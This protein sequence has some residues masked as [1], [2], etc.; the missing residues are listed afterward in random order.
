MGDSRKITANFAASDIRNNVVAEA[1]PSD[2]G[3]IRFQPVAPAGGYPINRSV[4][5][6]AAAQT[7]YVFSHWIGDLGGE[8]NPSSLLLSSDKGIVAVF[9]PTITVYSSPSEGGSVSLNPDQ[10][11]SGYTAGTDVTVSATPAEGY[12]FVGW[13]G[14]DVSGS[15]KSITVTVDAPKTITARFTEQSASRWWV[16]VVIGL[17]GLCGAL[18]LARVAYAWINHLRSHEPAQPED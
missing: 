1:E 3:S 2:G 8:Q 7:G 17:A 18:I 10:T 12:R 9:N 6:Y 5:V 4:F 11:G 13:E 14:E 15:D 16:W